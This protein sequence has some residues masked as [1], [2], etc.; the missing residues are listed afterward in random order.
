MVPIQMRLSTKSDI[1][2]GQEDLFLL[3]TMRM[4]PVQELRKLLD[5]WYVPQTKRGEHFENNNSELK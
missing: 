4:F 1:L 5:H 2:L 3:K